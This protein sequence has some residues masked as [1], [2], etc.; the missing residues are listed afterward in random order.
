[1]GAGGA[2][3]GAPRAEAG[4]RAP[5]AAAARPRAVFLLALS[6]APILAAILPLAACRDRP[7]A[8]AVREWPPAGSVEGELAA[9]EEHRYRLRL[10]AGQLVRLA[11]E[12]HGLDVAV[13]MHAPG[14]E[15]LL[16]VD[17]PTSGHGEELVL[18]ISGEAG[19]HVLGVRAP[20]SA[21]RYTARLEA[22]RPATAADRRAVRTYRDFAEAVRLPIGDA[23]KLPRLGNAV[24]A[25]QRLGEGDLEAEARFRLAQEHYDARDFQRA[26]TD[27]RAA[28]Q[29]FA[30]SGDDVWEAVARASLGIALVELAETERAIA[31]LQRALV[32]ARAGDQTYT[33]AR[34][35]DAL[36]KA[37]RKQGDLQQA[38]DTY[39]EALPAWPPEDW[40]RALTQHHL[41]VLHARFLGD[42]EDGRK[43]LEEA[44]DG[45]PLPQAASHKASTLDQLGQLELDEGRPA[46]ARRHFEQALELR[47]AADPCRRGLTLA[48]LAL[49]ETQQK[50]G[51]AAARLDEALAAVEPADCAADRP[52]VLETAGRLWEAAG[53]PDRALAEFQQCDALFA[54]Q[55]DRGGRIDCLAGL[56]RAHRAAGRPAEALAASG[57]ALTLVE[58]VRP[59]ILRDDL[60]RS[61]FAAAQ[62]LYDLHIELLLAQGRAEEAWVTAERARAR[63][64]RDLLAAAD[65]ADLAG[66][67]AGRL[68]KSERAL[69]RRLNAAETRRLEASRKQ[70][71]EEAALQARRVDALIDELETLR[72]ERRRHQAPSAAADGTPSLAELRSHLDGDELLLELR[73]GDERS[74]LWAVDRDSLA[75]VRLP[76]RHKVEEAASKAAYVQRSPRTVGVD[77]QPTCDL[78]RM[79][80]G[81]V[82]ERLG[83]RP[84][85]LV[86]DGVLETVSFAALPDPAAEG[87][88]ADAP[89][90]VARHD[91]SYLPSAATL[92]EQRRRLAGRRP[93]KGWV[94][95]VADPVYGAADRRAPDAAAGRGDGTAPLRLRFAGEE[96][97]AILDGLPRE[98]TLAAIGFAASRRRVLSGELGGFRVVHFAT[99]GT[100]D[101]SRPLWLS[102][103]KLARLDAAGDP[104][105]G[106]LY[107][108]E[109]YRLDLPAE[110][111]VL[112]ACDTA[113]GRY[114]R[115]E[116]LVAGL[117]RA[118]LHAGAA[119][120]VVSLGEVDDRSGRDLME[121]FYDGVLH[122]GE[123]PARAL[124][125]A[126]LALRR[127]RHR[128]RDWAP[129]V[130]QGD[131]RPLPPFE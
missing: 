77:P 55:G 91:I 15:P 82:A 21:G 115:G 123:P 24:A 11:V 6:L 35:L 54:G 110:L 86:P 69:Q 27:F 120:V 97:D 125:E 38:L 13:T 41:G 79:L 5:L 60:R 88:C 2:S 72:G 67:D 7:A 66:G 78:S 31:Q 19:G 98:R 42:T 106:D 39:G 129:F 33:L 93:A 12:Q 96:A 46:A 16:E 95:V 30:E 37:H 90:L 34:T 26:A 89:P 63:S 48:R 101:P 3:A 99:H 92:A 83:E 40:H 94:A 113:A 118:F 85:I 4:A 105:E 102:D 22:F 18:M 126:Q 10:P 84:L 29:L 117:P 44:R 128:P 8:G 121:R 23:G 59:R 52:T 62:D 51:A 112:S 32:L 58:G 73:L 61:H 71:P 114:Q 68:D 14:G 9:G 50:G 64:L 47:P 80:L 76:P 130:L 104:V 43:W 122:R 107:A 20:E 28:A 56:A 75:A 1:M 100:L 81:G 65:L 25:F 124:R 49:A 74:T 131:P 53:D 108:H 111:V 87:D 70:D 57:D 109:I 17:R 127:A 45:W 36:G 103:L 119:R 116:G